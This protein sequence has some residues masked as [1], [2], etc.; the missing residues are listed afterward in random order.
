MPCVVVIGLLAILTGKS[1][2]SYKMEER[3]K[4]ESDRAVGIERKSR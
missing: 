4:L 3:L 2:L 1:A